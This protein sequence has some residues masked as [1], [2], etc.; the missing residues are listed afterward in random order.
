MAD[1]LVEVMSA[2]GHLSDGS[3]GYDRPQAQRRLHDRLRILEHHTAQP[4]QQ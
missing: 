4:A 3:S 1:E 2:L